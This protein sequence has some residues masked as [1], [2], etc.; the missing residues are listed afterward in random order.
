MIIGQYWHITDKLVLA[1]MFSD[2]SRELRL[3]CSVTLETS[4]A[5]QKKILIKKNKNEI[6][7]QRFWIFQRKD[8]FVL[9]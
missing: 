8:Y 7:S 9:I 2:K 5:L 6:E 1:Y 3:N 4:C